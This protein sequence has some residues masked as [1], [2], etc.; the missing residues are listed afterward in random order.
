MRSSPNSTPESR[1]AWVFLPP[2]CRSPACRHRWLSC[3]TT[4]RSRSH[5]RFVGACHGCGPGID[6]VRNRAGRVR[7]WSHGHR[8]RRRRGAHADGYGP[9]RASPRDLHR[10]LP[11]DRRPSSRRRRHRAG[12]RAESGVHR[13]GHRTGRRCDRPGCRSTRDP[14]PVPHA[15][16]GQGRGHRQRPRGQGP[17]HRDGDPHPRNADQTASRR[18]RGCVGT[19]DLPLLARTD[20]RADGRGQTQGR[21]ADTQTP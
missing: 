21:R 9:R 4:V 18:R 5:G 3:R 19:G 10:R 14:R 17:G 6:A 20:R 15:V 8:A 12:V 2:A 7:S 1:D 13:D 11:L 16:G